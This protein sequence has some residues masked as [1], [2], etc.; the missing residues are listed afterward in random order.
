MPHRKI[1]ANVS[2]PR[3]LLEA[4]DSILSSSRLEYRTRAEFVVEAVRARILDLLKEKA[5]P[6]EILHKIQ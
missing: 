6:G 1:Y 2:L 5:V 3:G 4:V